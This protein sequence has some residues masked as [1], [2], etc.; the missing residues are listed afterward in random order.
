VA[1]LVSPGQHVVNMI[2]SWLAAHGVNYYSIPVTQDFVK[3]TV[4]AKKASEL[5]ATSFHQFV[6][7]STGTFPYIILFLIGKF[8]FRIQIF[9]RKCS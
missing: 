8:A 7:E 4:T 5:L 6:H 9:S 1:E 2:T 3:A